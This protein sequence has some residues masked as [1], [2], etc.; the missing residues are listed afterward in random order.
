M[1][2]EASERHSCSVN[3]ELG[4]CMH[5]RTS[6]R[7][8][9]LFSLFLGDLARWNYVTVQQAIILFMFLTKGRDIIR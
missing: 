5:V 7:F 6:K 8:P 4:P 3:L 9:C 1:L 2:A